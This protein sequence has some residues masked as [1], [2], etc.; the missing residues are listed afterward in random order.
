MKS[1]K[2]EKIDKIVPKNLESPSSDISDIPVSLPTSSS[3][4]DKDIARQ[5]QLGPKEIECE[6]EKAAVPRAAASSK[7]TT[8][9]T[10]ETTPRFL[11]VKRTDGE[12][13]SKVS[14]FVIS[15]SLYGLLGK[16]SNVKKIKEGLLVETVSNNQ[17]KRLLNVERLSTFPVEITPHRSLNTCKGVIY[18]RDL[19]NC[20]CEEIAEELRPQ[21][22]THVSRMKTRRNG[23]I[24]ETPSHILTFNTPKLPNIV[25]AAFYFLKVRAYVPP[26]LRCFQCQKYGH[27]SSKCS[28]TEPPICVCGKARHDGNPCEKPVTC[29]NCEGDHPANSR[30]CP[31]YIEEMNIQQLKINEKLT[32][33]E[34]KRKL[35]STNQVPTI[36]YAQ[37]TA[38][39][40]TTDKKEFIKEIE[41][42][43]SELIT[44][45]M[46]PMMTKIVDSVKSRGLMPPPS[47]TSSIDRLN[48]SQESLLSQNK[49]KRSPTKS[50]DL[51]SDESHADSDISNQSRNKRGRG[52]PKGKPRKPNPPLNDSEMKLCQSNEA[53]KNT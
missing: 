44:N 3:R 17:A 53:L 9:E 24:V 21:G 20:T 14:P 49:R 2:K 12:D 33:N 35:K 31:F 42:V 13:F 26:P 16:V 51:S 36:S 39:S 7:T 28:N 25:Y 32:Y 4:S 37:V 1:Q 50:C 41:P 43:L 38:S 22:V 47:F 18:N 34:A 40:K 19:L 30:K 15:K 46:K 29:V 6:Y 48:L 45:I 8:S 10:A 11:V 23:Q 27:T 52:W 5:Q